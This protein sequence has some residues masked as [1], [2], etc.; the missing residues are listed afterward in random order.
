MP[1]KK[2]IPN[3]RNKGKSKK[4]SLREKAASAGKNANGAVTESEDSS[5][6]GTSKENTPEK[7]EV[8]DSVVKDDEA[9]VEVKAAVASAE[10]T[11]AKNDEVKETAT[12][13]LEAL[14]EVLENGVCDHGDEPEL[15][16]V[17]EVEDQ[18]PDNVVPPV[19]PQQQP[20]QQQP[21]EI[22]HVFP[23]TPPMTPEPVIKHPL[24][25]SWTFWWFYNDT[26]RNWEDNQRRVSTVSFVEDFWALVHH[27]TDVREVRAGTDYSLFK[28]GTKPM[29]E[30]PMNRAGGRWTIAQNKEL[31]YNRLGEQWKEI[32]MF[33]IG[34]FYER[35]AELINGAVVSVRNKGDRISVWLKNNRPVDLVRNVGELFKRGV[36]G[37][38]G[39][40]S[41]EAHDE[42]MYRKSSTVRTMFKC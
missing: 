37:P 22:Q 30:D 35:E 21:L 11:A 18:E 19:P 41:Y 3:S 12:P 36:N 28:A 8:V 33:L 42:N 4:A 24:N 6:P 20:Q 17:A 15:Q 40:F 39:A 27:V 9:I 26:T 10:E 2:I 23:P 32:M 29:W 13:P 38:D 5:S 34:E 25:S 7:V 1:K 14:K 16:Q 31:R